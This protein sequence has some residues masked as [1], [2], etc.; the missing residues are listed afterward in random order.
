LASRDF[1]GFEVVNLI[2]PR[3]VSFKEATAALGNAIGKPGLRFVQVSYD[4][5]AQGMLQAGLSKQMVDLYVEM[6]QGAA[7]G[8]LGPEPGT[9]VVNTRTTIE[10]FAERFAEAYRA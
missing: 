6:Y 1:E 5:A 10:Q 8:L 9:K 4:E 2:G 3:L 7:R